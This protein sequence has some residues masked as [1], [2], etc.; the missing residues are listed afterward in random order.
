ML[1][2][3]PFDVAANVV[4]V[5]DTDVDVG[6]VNVMLSKIDLV[7]KFSTHILNFILCNLFYCLKRLKA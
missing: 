4:V 5:V 7:E 6:V 2:N 1:L 3:T